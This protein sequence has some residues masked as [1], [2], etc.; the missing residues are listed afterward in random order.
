MI[1]LKQDGLK[2]CGGCKKVAYCS[3]EHQQAHWK[4]HKPECQRTARLPVAE[5]K[6]DVES[7]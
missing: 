7:E 6:S 1:G 4:T 3:P 5:E 2:Y